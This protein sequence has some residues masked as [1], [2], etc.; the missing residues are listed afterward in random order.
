MADLARVAELLAD[1]DT[2]VRAIGSG[3]RKGRQVAHRR[4]E[5]RYVDLKGGRCLQVTSYDDTAAHITNHADPREVIATLV[6]EPYANWHLETTTQVHQVRVSKKGEVYWHTSDREAEAK[7]GHDQVKK[8][9]LDPG[10]PIFGVLGLADARGRIKPS[11]QSKYRQVE[12]FL[13]ILTASV[14]GAEAA[15]V[16]AAGEPLRVVDLGC[17]NGYLTFAA[18]VLLGKQRPVEV[19]GIDVKEQSRVH[20]NRV[21]AELGLTGVTFAVGRIDS[22][23]LP[24][25]P[26]VVLALHACDTATDDC[27]ARAISWEAPLILA[28]PCCHHDLSR[29]LRQ[30][31]VPDSYL[32]LVRDGILRERFADTL[33]DA[34]RADILRAQ[35]Y[36]VEVME[37]VDS[38]HT[39]RNTLIRAVRT[40]VNQP[41]GSAELVA[42]LGLQPRLV[43]LLAAAGG[44][45]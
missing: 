28:A 39:P 21:A 44:Q 31:Q 38:A 19:L 36:R 27:L 29:Q 1:S 26:H 13:R 10:E 6:A 14:E 3:R 42:T 41:D 35:G 25:Q 18:A 15:G 37:F 22:V 40:G 34:V 16:L 33:T 43:E 2:L 32:P 12:E 4:V 23:E 24:W 30:A 20:N 5:L 8:R 7:R 45:G 17:G 11:R 9:L